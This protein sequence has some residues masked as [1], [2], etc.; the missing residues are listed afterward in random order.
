MTEESERK[1]RRISYLSTEESDEPERKMRRLSSLSS[2]TEGR[3]SVNFIG[4]ESLFVEI[5]NKDSILKDIPESE[6][7]EYLYETYKDE[8]L[9]R[10]RVVKSV[11]SDKEVRSVTCS[12]AST[13]RLSSLESF[14]SFQGD[15]MQE[16]TFVKQRLELL[17]KV[18]LVQRQYLECEG[19][20]VVYEY[21]LEGLL[22]LVDSEFGFIGEVKHDEEGKMYLHVHRATNIA[23]DEPTKKF[24]EENQDNLRFYNMDTLYGRYVVSIG[25]PGTKL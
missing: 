3:T 24:Y 6:L 10:I 8:I 18:A 23:W 5:P 14:Q 21:L 1:M 13:V 16:L 25:S 17:E 11:D 19:P 2:L 22:D 12:D 4:D 20:K 15:T 9:D 7:K